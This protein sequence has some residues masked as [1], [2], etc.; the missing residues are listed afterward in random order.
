MNATL[1]QERSP[2]S[3]RIEKILVTKVKKY[4][5]QRLRKLA[6]DAVLTLAWDGFYQTYT[7]VLRRMAAE[8]HLDAQESE[9]LVQEAWARVIVHLE[10]F[11]WQENGAGLRGWLYTLI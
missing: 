1:I 11:H 5:E 4:L 2:R 7:E 3:I 10:S 6:P 9:D 8:F